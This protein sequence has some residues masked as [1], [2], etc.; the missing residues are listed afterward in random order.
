MLANFRQLPCGVLLEIEAVKDSYV[1]WSAIVFLE[2]GFCGTALDAFFSA[3]VGPHHAVVS[4]A[5]VARQIATP[6]LTTMAA[7]PV[8]ASV[9]FRR[10]LLAHDVVFYWF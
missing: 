3:G 7:G 6:S 4:A 2:L 1:I 9:D 8:P 10:T 5:P